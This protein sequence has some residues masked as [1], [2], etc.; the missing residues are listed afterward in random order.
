MTSSLLVYNSSKM[1]ST[2]RT[3][4]APGGANSFLKELTQF[5]KAEK[6]KMTELLPLL[7]NKLI[8]PAMSS[9]D[10]TALRLF[11]AQPFAEKIYIPIFRITTYF[12][13]SH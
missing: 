12:F 10:Q 3:E 6:T 7:F 4:F 2:L 9:P 8:Q 1:G 13:V 11:G 5:K